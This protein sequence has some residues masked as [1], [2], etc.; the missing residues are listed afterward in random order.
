MVALVVWGPKTPTTVQVHEGAHTLNV[1]VRAGTI[2]SVIGSASG[3]V[4]G[5]FSETQTVRRRIE[6]ELK[7][8]VKDIGIGIRASRAEFDAEIVRIRRQGYSTVSD[9]PVPGIN[10]VAAPVFDGAGALALALTLI[11]PIDALD[12]GPRSA[13]IAELLATCEELSRAASGVQSG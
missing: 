7:G 12:L 6:Q 4:F 11:G 1:N 10:A 2:F 3:R 13:A 8:E 5:A 9:M